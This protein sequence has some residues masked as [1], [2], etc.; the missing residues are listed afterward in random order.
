[1]F[2]HRGE[3]RRIKEAE[4]LGK[5]HYKQQGLAADFHKAM[6]VRNGASAKAQI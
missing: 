1:M 6:G 5:A 4:K 2:R 3:T